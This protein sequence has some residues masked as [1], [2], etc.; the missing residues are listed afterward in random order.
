MEH[1]IANSAIVRALRDRFFALGRSKDANRRLEMPEINPVEWNV[2]EFRRLLDEPFKMIGGASPDDML[3]QVPNDRQRILIATDEL[4]TKECLRPAELGEEPPGATENDPNCGPSISET[5]LATEMGQ[6]SVTKSISHQLDSDAPVNNAKAVLVLSIEMASRSEAD[7]VMEQTDP[8]PG[9]TASTP[10]VEVEVALEERQQQVELSDSSLG[11]DVQFDATL[12]CADEPRSLVG[13]VSGAPVSDE[14]PV[15]EPDSQLSQPADDTSFLAMG[16]DGS[17]TSLEQ[18]PSLE[19]ESSN[20]S[21]D[22]TQL[23]LPADPGSEK[24]PAFL[25]ADQVPAAAVSDM[26][27]GGTAWMARSGA[28]TEG[29]TLSA[30]NPADLSVADPAPGE[31][32]LA[33]PGDANAECTVPTVPP[34]GAAIDDSP[35]SEPD[36]AGAEVSRLIAGHPNP[37]QFSTSVLDGPLAQETAIGEGPATF[38]GS[39]AYCAAEKECPPAAYA[40]IEERLPDVRRGERL[41]PASCFTSLERRAPAPIVERAIEADGSEPQPNR[42]GQAPAR[43]SAGNLRSLGDERGAPI[44]ATGRKLALLKAVVEPDLRTAP[45]DRERAIALRWALRDIRG[46]RLG[47]LPVDPVTLQTLVDLSLIEISDGKPTLTSSGFNVIA[48]T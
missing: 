8:T 16:S 27:V 42:S 9:E 17:L 4:T 31:A 1:L 43:F 46:N 35:V 30:S 14:R 37:N 2:E 22:G 23:R 15:T 32:S 45:V 20:Q 11:A 19:N 47:I 18:E 12:Q 10:V 5:Q 34:A 48:S 44:P 26:N 21:S 41:Q 3:D 13:E 7:A 40:E 33:R 6:A 29:L 39:Q 36:D 28:T 24:E 25:K 38:S